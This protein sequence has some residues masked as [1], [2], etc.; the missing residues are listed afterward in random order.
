MNWRQRQNLKL[1]FNGKDSFSS[2]KRRHALLDFPIVLD[3]RVESLNLLNAYN[4]Q[5][6]NW[7]VHVLFFRPPILFRSSCLVK[8]DESY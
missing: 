5:I 6:W 2:F 7:N 4:F 8:V 1:V 3:T